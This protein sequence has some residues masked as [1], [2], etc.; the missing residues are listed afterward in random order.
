MTKPFT[1][2]SVC[3]GIEAA[4]VAWEP[5]G[6]RPAAFS[7]IDPLAC[8]VLAHRQRATRPLFMP[9]PVA[10]PGRRRCLSAGAG[11]CAGKAVV[12][13]RL[14]GVDDLHPSTPDA[15]TRRTQRLGPA[16][17]GHRLRC[18]DHVTRQRDHEVG[19]VN[20]GQRRPAAA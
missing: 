12:S 11:S 16:A 15:V 8:H 6:W 5:L 19:A 20:P 18:L 17:A 4:S 2:L 7:E 10:A 9:D 14:Q 3:S 13:L 1:Y